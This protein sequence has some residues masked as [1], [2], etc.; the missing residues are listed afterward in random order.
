MSKQKPVNLARIDITLDEKRALDLVAHVR[1][2]F[3]ASKP[4]VLTL[5]KNATV[6]GMIVE[7]IHDDVTRSMDVYM[8][9][10]HLHVE[11]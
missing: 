9:Y 8:T 3:E 7:F 6:G 5:D 4:L 1:G 10:H 11:Y 2:T